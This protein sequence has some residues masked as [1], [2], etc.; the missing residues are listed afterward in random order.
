MA[1]APTPSLFG[2]SHAQPDRGGIGLRIIIYYTTLH[3]TTLHYTTLH[4]TTLHYTTLRYATLRY[5]TL[6]YATRHYTTLYYACFVFFCFTFMFLLF[7]LHYTILY[8]GPRAPLELQGADLPWRA[9][10][11]RRR[12]MHIGSQ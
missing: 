11:L 4:Y 3:Y 10:A 7:T 9:Q 12:E 5:A 8:C 6:H 1:H 2:A